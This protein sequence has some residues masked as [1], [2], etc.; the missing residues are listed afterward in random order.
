VIA[1][2]NAEIQLFLPVWVR[3]RGL[4][5]FQMVFFGSQAVGAL[6]W[7]LIAD[8]GG[9]VPAFLVAA[10]ALVVGTVT[11]RWWP[12]IDVTGLSRDLSAHWEEP[13]LV[14]Q[15][16]PEEGPVVVTTA[17]TVAKHK[18]EAFLKAMV[19]VRLSRL[20]T[21]AISWELYRE[22]E[23][24]NRFIELFTVPTWGEHL[25]QHGGRQ[26]VGDAVIDKRVRDLSD[27]KPTTR[28]FFPTELVGEDWGWGDGGQGK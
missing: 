25:Q 5:T 6:A 9:L 11:I 3:A 18:H 15:A 19:A 27:P 7:G 2:T 16:D 4:A 22:G 14:T 10:G 12:M 13:S 28:H 26:T 8:H 17:Y 20:R 21:G 1:E 23:T 24:D